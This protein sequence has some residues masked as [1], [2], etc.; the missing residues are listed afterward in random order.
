MPV[1]TVPC[2]E[3]LIRGSVS[4]LRLNDVRPWVA[5][6]RYPGSSSSSHVAEVCGSGLPHPCFFGEFELRLEHLAYFDGLLAWRHPRGNR[7]RTLD[8]RNMA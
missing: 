7:T 6:P 8:W 4:V 5:M 2:R 3:G 1:C